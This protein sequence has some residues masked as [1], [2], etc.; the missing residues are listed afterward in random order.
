MAMDK[1]KYHFITVKGS[2]QFPFDML[3]YDAC[4]PAK[5]TDSYKLAEDGKRFVV[6]KTLHYNAP[7]IDRWRSFGW[8][9][10]VGEWDEGF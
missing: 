4:I 5:E 9:A 10:I 6:L 3:R 2:G 8:R 7:T 1:A